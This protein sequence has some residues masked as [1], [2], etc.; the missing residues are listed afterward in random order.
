M[1]DLESVL[2]QSDEEAVQVLSVDLRSWRGY[3]DVVNVYYYPWHSLHY[4]V[5]EPLEGLCGI[6]QSEVHYREFK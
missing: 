4:P 3:Q 6:S 1:V 2:A 5:H